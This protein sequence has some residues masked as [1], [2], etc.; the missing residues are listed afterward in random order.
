MMYLKENLPRFLG[1][2]QI[3]VFI[4][5][6]VSERLLTRIANNKDIASNLGNI[7]SHNTG[8]RISTWLALANSLGI[9]I[10]GILFFQVFREKYMILATIALVFFILE[11]LILAVSKYGAFS[12]IP[13]SQNFNSLGAS[14]SSSLLEQADF[15]FNS[16]DRRGYDLHM[17]FFCLGGMLWYYLLVVSGIVPKFIGI[18]GLAA[19]SLLLIPVIMVLINRESTDLM[20]LG[21]LYLP[22]ELV[23]GIWLFIKG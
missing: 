14:S 15:L 12:L 8:W 9:I 10:L 20:I 23:F 21:V 22:F 1:A 7:I 17:L 16:V 6:L 3:F 2:A 13:I 4:A 5:S 11:G 19:V 18:W